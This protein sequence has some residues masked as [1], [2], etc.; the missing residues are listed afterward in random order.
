MASR[1]NEVVTNWLAG[2]C[3]DEEYLKSKASQISKISKLTKEK[4]WPAIDPV[5]NNRELVR[6]FFPDLDSEKQ[7]TDSVLTISA[8]ILRATF[9]SVSERE[10]VVRAY[11]TDLSREAEFAEK[12]SKVAAQFATTDEV[13]SLKVENGKGESLGM[14]VRDRTPAYATRFLLEDEQ[15]V[16]EVEVSDFATIEIR[17]VALNVAQADWGI[18]FKSAIKKFLVSMSP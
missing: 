1:Q 2:F 15:F 13:H 6:S 16:G 11:L 18:N 8:G 17:G 5:S 14:F 10:F 12:V 7:D 4:P 3:G 9:E